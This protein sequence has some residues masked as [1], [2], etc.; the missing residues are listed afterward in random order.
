MLLKNLFRCVR[1]GARRAQP[2]LRHLGSPRH[3]R[4]A[5]KKPFPVR[6][7]GSTGPESN[8]TQTPGKSLFY[9][10]TPGAFRARLP[11]CF[12][13][14]GRVFSVRPAAWA[15]RQA[16]H[17]PPSP[18]SLLGVGSAAAPGGARGLVVAL[19]A[20][21]CALFSLVLWFFCAPFSPIRL[22]GVS[23][24]ALGYSGHKKTHENTN[25][26]RKR[27]ILRSCQFLP[28][29]TILPKRNEGRRR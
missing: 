20:F 25:Q 18:V 2:Q 9:G 23:S 8:Q 4:Y 6:P 15:P 24:G 13:V 28:K 19:T 10:R 3:L 21:F 14:L 7:A 26:L 22:F 11:T 16:P 12:C 5:S 27:R 1:W 29:G 17:W